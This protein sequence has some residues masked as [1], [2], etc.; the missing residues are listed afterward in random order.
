M[1]IMYFKINGISCSS[2]I[3]VITD[4]LYKNNNIKKVNINTKNSNAEIKYDEN[5]IN[6]VEIKKIIENNGYEVTE[7]SDKPIKNKKHIEILQITGIVIVIASA[8]LIIQN[9]IGFNFIPKIDQSMGYVLL[10]IA[11]LFTSL[12]CIAMCG[13]INISQSIVRSDSD[14]HDS[15]KNFFNSIFYNTGRVI[16]YTVLGGFVGAIGSLLSFSNF[17]IMPLKII[18]GITR[19]GIKI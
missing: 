2:C 1:S 11:G 13:G 4:V 18:C 14:K 9:T 19:N 10:F 17:T 12:H 15:K 3:K 16:S 8:L 5:K 7:I 6:K